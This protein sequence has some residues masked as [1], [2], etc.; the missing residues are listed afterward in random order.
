VDAGQG[1][2]GGDGYMDTIYGTCAV[3]GM[4]R[5]GGRWA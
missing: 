3:V 1:R 4:W 2:A 5:H